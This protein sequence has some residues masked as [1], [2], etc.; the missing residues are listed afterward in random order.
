[1]RRQESWRYPQ[2]IFIFF[3]PPEDQHESLT[4]KFLLAGIGCI[5]AHFFINLNVTLPRP[6]KLM[7]RLLIFAALF[8]PLFAYF[9]LIRLSE[10]RISYNSDIRPV[11]NARCISCHGGVK[12]SAKLS[13]LTRGEALDTAESGLPAIVPGSAAESEMIRRL[14]HHDPEERMPLEAEPLDEETI[15]LFERW[16]DEGAEWEE[17]WAFVAPQPEPVPVS[18]KDWA[19]NEIDHFVYQQLEEEGIKP[20]PEADKNT[21]LRRLYL[22]LTGLPPS[23]AEAEAFLSDTTADAYEKLVDQL[24]ASPHYGE[25]W[26]SMWLDLARYADSKGYEKDLDR[27]IWKYRDWLIQAF[28]QNMPFDQFTVEQLAGDLL[29]KPSQQQL[30]ATAFHRNTMSNDEG[31]TRNEEF[32]A[33]A[34]VDRVSTTYEVWQGLTMSCVQCHTHP[35]DPI[36]HEEFYQTMAYF[37]NTVDADMYNE[38]PNLFTYE[39]EDEDKVEKLIT[40]LDEKLPEEVKSDKNLLLHERKQD[41]LYRLDYRKVEAESMHNNH[42]VIELIPDG[43]DVVWQIQDSTWI[44]FEDVDLREVEAVS[45]RVATP[46]SGFI[47]IRRDSLFGPKLGEVTINTTGKWDNPMMVKP[48]EHMWRTLRTSIPETNSTHDLYYLFRQYKH[49]GQHLFHLDW[50]YYHESQQTW[51]AYDDTFRD[52]LETLYSIRPLPTPILQELPPKRRR[53]NRVFERGNWLVKGREVEPGVPVLLQQNAGEERK[54]RLAFARWLVGEENPL[55]ARV[56]VNRFWEQLFGYGI[57][58]TLEDFGSQGFPPSHPALLDWLA[59]KFSH[60]FAWDMKKLIKVMV[61][62]ATYR[63]SSV[64]SQEKYALDPKNRL[65]ARGPKVRLSAEQ[66]R[67]QAL[68]VSGLLNNKMF[69]PSIQPPRPDGSNSGWTDWETAEAE[70]QHRRGIYV[71]WRRTDPY[72]SMITF[73][74]PTRTLCS[75]RRIRTNTPLQALTLLNDPVYYQAAEALAENMAEEHPQDIRQQI[76]SGYRTAMLRDP[77][78]AKLDLLEAMYQEALEHYSA[79]SATAS[80]DTEQKSTII[81]DKEALK[82]VANTIMNMDEF[83]NKN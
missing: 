60:D 74:S 57:V 70:E 22:D 69:G 62:S 31:G 13:F 38:R 64:V 80:A 32:R 58:E 20:N 15:R 71:F 73:D 76:R 23:P 8:L 81:P 67:D 37:N 53:E 78:E 6:E 39:G 16:I 41:L 47:E 54:D 51:K 36:R 43:Q 44:M 61:M 65:L 27:S 3:W 28:N 33:A 55:T 5:F 48:E 72:P 18:G 26:A 35:Y 7:R 68:A 75:S 49:P 11:I 34:M 59:V 1:M 4:G 2:K 63:Q 66:I 17:H 79:K 82:L 21:L 10:P 52:T 42:Q 14:R 46:L 19:T 12:A 24:L 50:I 25:K 30:I 45:F 77:T 9:L 29:P 40:W 56:T 83:I